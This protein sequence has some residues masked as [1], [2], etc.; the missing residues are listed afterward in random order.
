M[1]IKRDE[2]V[3]ESSRVEY[4]AEIVPGTMIVCEDERDAR[5]HAEVLKGKVY[6][7]MHYES[8]WM[9]AA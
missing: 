8:A 4:G 3:V 2:F 1:K 9:E 7:R 6:A 5:L